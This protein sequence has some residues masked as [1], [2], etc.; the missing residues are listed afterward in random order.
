MLNEWDGSLKIDEN[1]NR[2]YAATGIFGTKDSQNNTFT[3]TVV[4]TVGK[5][6]SQGI[7]SPDVKSGV[8]GYKD[9]N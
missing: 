6:D 8:F 3:G 1:N 7:A 5:S 9:G 4:G 2:I